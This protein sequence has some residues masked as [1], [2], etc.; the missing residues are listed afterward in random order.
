MCS[1][2]LHLDRIGA[3]I[4]GLHGEVLTRVRVA[5]GASMLLSCERRRREK[6]LTIRESDGVGLSE[7]EATRLDT[8]AQDARGWPRDEVRLKRS[9]VLLL[10]GRGDLFLVAKF[11]DE[12]SAQEGWR[13]D[14]LR[15][16][17]ERLL[18]TPPAIDDT[19]AEAL[20]NTLA[21]TGGNKSETARLLRISRQTVYNFVK[22]PKRSS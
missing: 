11:A 8:L 10:A 13:R 9:G 6:S 17:A 14:F 20:R 21:L 16:V 2:D 22:R 12:A 18:G 7:E 5:L 19:K 1:S 4:S 15:F 3:G